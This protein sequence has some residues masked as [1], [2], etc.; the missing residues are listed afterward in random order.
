MTIYRGNGTPEAAGP[1]VITVTDGDRGDIVVTDNGASWNIDSS[2]LSGAGRSLIN[3][4]NAAAQRTTLGLGY[5]STLDTVDNSD[6]LGTQ[7]SVTNGGTGSTTAS[8]ARTNLGLGTLATQNASNVAI[9]DGSIRVASLGIST[10]A[11]YGG[12]VTQ[13]TS[14]TTPVTLDKISG[15][16]TLFST[17]GSIV[18]TAFTVNN[19]LISAND[20]VIV[21]QKSGTNTYDFS[22]SNVSA[23]SFQLTFRSTLGTSTDAPVVNFV[24]IKSST[25]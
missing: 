9:T 11:G 14:R 23:G 1:V 20:V 18:Y 21:S 2:V 10:G 22:V 13:L 15:A 4:A 5:L 3:G 24:V 6:W 7:L 8:G 16:I 19:S 25:N 17:A 12:T